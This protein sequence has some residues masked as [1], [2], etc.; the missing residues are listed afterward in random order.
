MNLQY[1]FWIP[2]M[3]IIL[4]TV[5]SGCWT[6]AIEV[7]HR[8]ELPVN[9][10]WTALEVDDDA[11][12]DEWWESFRDP[13]LKH[14]VELGLKENYNL[15]GA[16]AR[17]E[18]AVAQALIVGADL[19]PS[20][21]A[22]FNAGKQKQN[23]I[24]FPIP[25]AGDQVLS[26]TS[27][28]YGIS[29]DASWEPDVW[30]R[31]SAGRFAAVADAAA[32]EADFRGA[33]LSLAAQI[34]KS[35]FAILE[36]QAQVE[37]AEKTVASYRDTA[38]QVRSRY[39]KGLQ[40]SLDL[41]LARSS[42]ASAEALL[43]QRTM[44]FD[45]AVR[46]LEILLGRYP[47]AKLEVAQSLPPIPPIPA[48]GIPSEVVSRRPD[49]I[50]AERRMWAAGARWTQAR[51]ALYP[52]FN[53]T[54]RIGTSVDEFRNTFDPDFYIWSI[55]GNIMQPVFQGGRLRAQITLQD[56]RSREAAAQWADSVLQA[57][58]EVETALAAERYLAKQEQHLIRAVEQ[59]AASHE[60]AVDRYE[61]GLESFVTVLEAQRRSLD[62][63]S[64]LLDVRRQRL[65]TRVNLHLALGGGFEIAKIG[66]DTYGYDTDRADA[67]RKEE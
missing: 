21:S 60:L 50:S 7:R 34:S 33:K 20:V 4:P 13:D 55:A 32:A 56:A 16:A 18:A 8:P 44:Q 28:S 36:S 25:G 27:E 10:E 15:D 1:R 63:E 23:F 24:G 12:L 2:L 14:L 48:V 5:A 37:L 58:V 54:G 26:Q 59:S 11:I 39:V 49:L 57:F 61:S 51:R 19:Y 40:S 42:L 67:D 52:G 29:L 62:A 41:R 31:I 43:A 45:L 46:Q 30:G 22:G 65:D 64:R 17:V 6:S 35:W 53:F 66:S 3:L 9:Q 38:Q 47:A